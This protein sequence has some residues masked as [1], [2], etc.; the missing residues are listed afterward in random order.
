M[1]L[2]RLDGEGAIYRQVYR[3]LRTAI[4]DGRVPPGSRLP[5]TRDVADEAGVARNRVVLAYRQLLDEG[6]VVGRVG[7][8]T[9]VA[10]ELPGDEHA[11]EPPRLQAP[12]GART[13]ANP[14]WQRS[15]AP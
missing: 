11:G 3:A 13:R 15:A 4:L 5:S 12:S 7:S 6:Y 8:G 9:Y 1:R 2:P 14:R 10:A